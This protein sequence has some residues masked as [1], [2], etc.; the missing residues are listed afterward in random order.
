MAAQ[1]R[2][3]RGTGAAERPSALR[4]VVGCAALIVI[5]A[6]L[7]AAGDLILPFIFS[8]IL[9]V[10]VYPIVA[11]FRR[12]KIPTLLAVL[13]VVGVI[14]VALVAAAGM[15]AAIA[16]QFSAAMP[17]Y[18]QKLG[19]LFASGQ[20]LLARLGIE[21]GAVNI[22]ETV[23]PATA[24]KLV[25]KT[26]DSLTSI[27]SQTTLVILTVAFMLFEVSEFSDKF[28][29]AFGG[30]RERMGRI[31]GGIEAVQRYLVLKTVA[32]AA[33]ALLLLVW[34]WILGLDFALLWGLLVFALNYVP[35]I[36]SIIAA[37][38]P[39]LLALVQLGP[40]SAILVAVGF[41]AVNFVIGN[42]IE[43]K[44][45]GQSLGLS[46]LVVFLSLIFWGWIWGPAGMLLS[47]PLTVVVKILLEHND[48]TRPIA[49]LLGPAVKP[50]KG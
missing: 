18:Q 27:L 29:K 3:E 38:P 49:I 47:V 39:I 22:G 35:N 17:G 25:G 37:I 44:M 48:D 33:T 31:A 36:G 7:K 5:V 40:L 12:K 28:Q 30:G 42:I 6:G 9:T 43:T 4:V 23:N 11:W 45:M 20:A 24:M 46:S 10:V 26:L 13:I 1:N 8:L 16:A 14:A 41:V 50:A 32:S 19:A 2:S 15:T 21:T 34:M